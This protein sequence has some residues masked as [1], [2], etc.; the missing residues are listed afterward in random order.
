MYVRL[1]PLAHHA[2][3]VANVVL[4]VEK[5]FLRQHVKD[6]AVF[7][8]VYAASRFN[9]AANVFALHVARP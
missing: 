6:F 1:E 8:Q 3:R 9:R 7:G 4:R 2:D 5:K